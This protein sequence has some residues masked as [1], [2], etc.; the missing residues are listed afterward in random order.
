MSATLR[1]ELGW[2]SSAGG[3]GGLGLLDSATPHWHQRI[4]TSEHKAEG[5]TPARSERR[6]QGVGS[7]NHSDSTVL[8][9]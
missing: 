8:Y 4:T 7:L 1:L 3:E 2:G 9:R 6:I 5:E